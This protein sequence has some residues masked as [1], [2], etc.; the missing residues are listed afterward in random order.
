MIFLQKNESKNRKWSAAVG[1]SFFEFVLLQHFVKQLTTHKST[2]KYL[3]SCRRRQTTETSKAVAKTRVC[4]N[5]QNDEDLYTATPKG[6]S[7][8]WI[9]HFVADD[10][11]WIGLLSEK[12]HALVVSSSAESSW[13]F[14]K[15]RRQ[16]C[17]ILLL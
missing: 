3:R 13:I 11:R 7:G 14:D 6:I 15:R 2:Q 5:L 8:D 4:L 9:P 1:N 16:R 12:C 17:V 10:F